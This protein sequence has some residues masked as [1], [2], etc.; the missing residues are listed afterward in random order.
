MTFKCVDPAF[1]IESLQIT[2]AASRFSDVR[3]VS[4]ERSEEIGTIGVLDVTVRADAPRGRFFGSLFVSGFG[5]S[6]VDDVPVR[7]THTVNMSGSVWGELIASDYMYRVGVV[8]PAGSFDRSV[9][10]KSRDG[11]PFTILSTDLT[12]SSMPMQITVHPIGTTQSEYRLQVTGEAGDYLGA[13]R[14]RLTVHTSIAAEPQMAFDV[15][16]MVRDLNAREKVR[17]GG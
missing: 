12:T 8:K 15:M 1:E 11:K 3:T 9:T 13:I 6:P 5:K 10:I 14:G 4:I 2:G 17:S 7:R 16:G